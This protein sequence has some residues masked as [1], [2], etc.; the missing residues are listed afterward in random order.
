MSTIYSII[1]LLAQ[2]IFFLVLIQLIVGLLMQFGVL[3]RR[4]AFAY[5]IYSGIDKL[6]APLLDPIRRVLP[7]TGGLDFSP[8]VLLLGIQIILIILRDLG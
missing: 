4:H 8:L 6:L 7:N 3:D 1:A 2:V 5:Q